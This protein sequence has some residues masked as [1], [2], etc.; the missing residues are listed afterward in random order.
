MKD[1]S[2]SAHSQYADPSSCGK[3]VMLSLPQLGQFM[4]GDPPLLDSSSPAPFY[5]QARGRMRVAR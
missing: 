2:Q 1:T 5:A 4:A 3:T